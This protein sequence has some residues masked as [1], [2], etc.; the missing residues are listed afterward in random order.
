VLGYF[1]AL[2]ALCVVHLREYSALW[3]TP[4]YDIAWFDDG[5]GKRSSVPQLPPLDTSPIRFSITPPPQANDDDDDVENRLPTL[6]PPTTD[7]TREK[8]LPSSP[9]VW[10]GRMFAGRAGRDHPFA[11]RR[12]GGR[13]EGHYYP[14]YHSSTEPRRNNNNDNNRA[15]VRSPTI[16]VS[17]ATLPSFRAQQPWRERPPRQQATRDELTRFGVTQDMPDPLTSPGPSFMVDT[18]TNE[19]EPIPIGDRSQWVRAPRTLGPYIPPP[20]TSWRGGKPN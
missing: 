14:S 12:P 9:K 2:V 11:I 7:Q 13:A 8:P 1:I 16:R 19:D 20:P 18:V 3:S 10:Y 15:I 17:A 5:D 4:I 6:A